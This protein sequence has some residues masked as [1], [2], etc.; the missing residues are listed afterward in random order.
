MQIMRHYFVMFRRSKFFVPV[1]YTGLGAGSATI[2]TLLIEERFLIW[3]FAGFLLAAFAS[4]IVSWIRNS[5]IFFQNS[6]FRIA[7][8]SQWI[9]KSPWAALSIIGYLFPTKLREEV[10]VNAANDLTQDWLE[11]RCAGHWRVFLYP[12]FSIRICWLILATVLVGLERGVRKL[13]VLATV[14]FN[15]FRK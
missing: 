9:P 7:S 5:R 6:M 14:V 3:V 15:H 12:V 4:D 8:L 13:P 10:F 11:A 1:V 2:A